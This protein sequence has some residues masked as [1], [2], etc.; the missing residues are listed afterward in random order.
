M[1]FHYSSRFCVRRNL[2][3]SI[4]VLKEYHNFKH[5]IGCRWSYW[6]NFQILRRP[7]SPATMSVYEFVKSFEC[8]FFAHFGANKWDF[9]LIIVWTVRN[10]PFAPR[11]GLVARWDFTLKATILRNSAFHLLNLVVLWLLVLEAWMNRIFTSS[12]W[13][14][15]GLRIVIMFSTHS[16]FATLLFLILILVLQFVLTLTVGFRNFLGLFY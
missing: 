5:L 9:G 4:F 16:L 10:V 12:F 1:S 3:L 6:F 8:F 7:S 15:V 14:L 11:I 2:V 13:L